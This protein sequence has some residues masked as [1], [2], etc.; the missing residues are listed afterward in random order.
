MADSAYAAGNGETVR[1]NDIYGRGR[2][3]LSLI[4]FLPCI[5][6]ALREIDNDFWFLLNH[7]RYVLEHGFPTVEPFTIHTGLDFVMQQWLSAVIF[8]LVYASFGTIG[9]KLLV[10][11]CYLLSIAIFYKLCMRLSKNFFFLSYL[12][13]IVF[14][15]LISYFMVERPFLFMTLI[16]LSEVFVL[17]QYAGN[18]DKRNTYKLVIAL[19]ILSMLLVSIQASMWLMLFV[20]MLPYIV[21]AFHF[22]IGALCGENLPKKPIFITVVLMAVAGFI[23]PYG[24]NAMT[25][26]LRSYGVKEI[27]SLVRE[28]FPTTVTSELGIIIFAMIVMIFLAYVLYRSDAMPV[29]YLFLILG[30]AYLGLSSYRGF[31]FFIIC[32]IFPLASHFKNFKIPEFSGSNSPRTLKIRKLL[33]TLVVIALICL[34]VVGGSQYK[35]MSSSLSNRDLLNAA[36]AVVK[37]DQGKGNIILYTGYN[38]GNLAEYNGIPA[39][40]DTRA[41]V[42]L[43]SN[44]H[45]EDILKEYYE[46]QTGTL[47]YKMFVE[48]YHFTHLILNKNAIEILKTYLAQDPDYKMIYSNEGY[49][50]YKSNSY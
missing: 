12:L 25:Y 36:V 38:D 13:T 3:Y 6:N 14:S 16:L 4:F 10:F 30:T 19:P 33:V 50:V 7:G 34:V 47:H 9:I 26:L 48:K 49:E 21:G 2:K 27:N 45:K 46:L 44:N 28:M 29:R 11:I 32:G 8:D 15:L 39:Y 31:I 1:R 43:K 22:K 5:F 40:L 35:N 20:L 42:F 18:P 37:Q 17:E 23:N 41:E 24:F